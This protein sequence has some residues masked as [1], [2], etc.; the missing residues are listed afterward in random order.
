MHLDYNII[1]KYFN[2]RYKLSQS[3]SNLNLSD[4]LNIL[5]N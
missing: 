1:E 3:D 5:L 4:F 2:N